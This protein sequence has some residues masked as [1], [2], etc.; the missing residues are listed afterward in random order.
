M[1]STAYTTCSQPKQLNSLEHS[2][3]INL[4]TKEHCPASFEFLSLSA[5]AV[6]LRTQ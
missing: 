3:E 1:Q 4:L 2:Q 6:M 5:L